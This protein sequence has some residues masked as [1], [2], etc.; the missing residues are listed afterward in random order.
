M[1]KWYVLIGAA[2]ILGAVAALFSLQQPIL[3]EEAACQVVSV[4]C[5]GQ[6]VSDQVDVQAVTALLQSYTCRRLPLG[7]LPAHNFADTLEIDLTVDG[8]PWRVTL[9]EADG[10]Y[11]AY[12]D[13]DFIHGIPDGAALWT[14]LSALMP[15]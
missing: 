13:A 12:R 5:R 2:L 10:V 1:K 14:E 3:E 7:A 9:S 4:Y 6:E 8:E 11:A 15:G